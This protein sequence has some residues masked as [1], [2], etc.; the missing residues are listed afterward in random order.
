M[1][2]RTWIVLLIVCAAGVSAGVALAR[3]SSPARSSSS[4]ST[5]ESATRSY[6]IAEHE[7]QQ[8]VN[9]AVMA[10]SSAFQGFVDHIQGECANVLAGAPEGGG[11]VLRLEAVSQLDYEGLLAVRPAYLRLREGGG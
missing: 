4:V 10:R 11:S 1:R 3:S 2:A 6:L 5:N 7:L 8:A 9:G